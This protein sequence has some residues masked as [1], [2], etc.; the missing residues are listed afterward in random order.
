MLDQ[1]IGQY[2][3]NGRLGEGGMGQ[4]F[5]AFDEKLH[6]TVA[7]KVVPDGRGSTKGC[8]PRSPRCEAT[9]RARSGRSRAASRA[10][11]R[12]GHFHHVELNV[13]CTLA[14]LG[15]NGEALRWLRSAM[16][17]GFPCLAAFENEMLLSSLRG[18]PEL[19]AMLAELRASRDRYRAVYEEIHA[20]L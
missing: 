20:A 18:E 19:G 9:P 7:V 2:R 10:A 14:L 12:F 16:Q 13:A 4:V 6:R 15:R 11:N 1:Q 3:I 5:S 8:A 17:N